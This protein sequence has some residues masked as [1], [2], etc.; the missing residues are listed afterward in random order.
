[1]DFP[2]QA[3]PIIINNTVNIDVCDFVWKAV[4]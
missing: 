1:M 3:A 2:W 4:L